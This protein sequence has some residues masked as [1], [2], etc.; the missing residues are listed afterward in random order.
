MATPSTSDK[1][2][3]LIPLT[4]WSEHHDWPP[5]GGLRHLRF[6][7]EKNGFKSAFKKIGAR[8]LV[9]E[10]EFFRCVEANDTNR[11]TGARTKG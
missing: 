11:Q 6:Y 5:E 2:T 4:K 1:Q 7:C 10:A 9:D 8:V 3:R